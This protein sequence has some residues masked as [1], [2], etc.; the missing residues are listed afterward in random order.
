VK[1][2]RAW[3]ADVE[4]V[5]VGDFAQKNPV[6]ETCD[7]TLVGFIQSVASEKYEIQHRKRQKQPLVALFKA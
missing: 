2:R 1:E 6:T 7:K 5:D 3:G 4:K